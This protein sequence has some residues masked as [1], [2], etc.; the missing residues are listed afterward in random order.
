[1]SALKTLAIAAALAVGASS[2]A[3]AQQGNPA[4]NAGA[5]GGSGTHQSSLKTGSASNTQK[6]L[7]N[8]NGYRHRQ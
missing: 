3:M 2:F 4:S 1:M 6:V 5:S 8:E 7:K